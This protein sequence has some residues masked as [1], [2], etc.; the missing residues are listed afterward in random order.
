MID[1]HASLSEKFLKKGFWL[2]LFSFI[3]APMGYIIKIILSWE[4]NVEEIGILYG[5]ISLI[6]L[7]SSY[8]DLG[9]SESLK[10]FIPKY[11]S[12][13]RYDKVKTIVF[14]ALLVQIFTSLIIAWVFI[15]WWNFI[16][17]NYFKSSQAKEVLQV[18]G[19]FLIW[20]NIIQ[21]INQF[22]YAIQ[23]TFFSKMSDFIKMLFTLLS[24]LF[25]FFWDTSSLL[26]YSISWIIWLYAGLCCSL[27]LFY[28]FYYRKYLK[29][30]SILIQQDILWE[31]SKYAFVVFIW[32]SSGTILSQID[33]Q[34][35]IY[36]LWSTDAWYYT[37]YLSIIWIPFM[38]IWPIFILLFPVFSEMNAKK[39][40]SKIK[41]TKQLFVRSFITIWLMFNIF[42]FV[43]SEIIAFSLFGE[44][45]ILSWEILK[46]SI[47]FLL[48]NFL[49]QINFNIMAGI[50]KVKERLR[51]IL[52]A[53]CFNFV[54]NL[55]LI[56]NIW[57]YGA[58]L[59]TWFG[60]MLIWSLSEYYL[61]KQYFIKHDFVSLLKNITLLGG[62]WVFMFYYGFPL[63]HSLSR[64]Q[65]FL[66]LWWLFIL[67]GFFFIC[68]NYKEFRF[69]IGEI[70]KLRK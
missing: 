62:L 10:Y 32:A 69:F 25:I 55:I 68:I 49:L 42:F 9:M 27:I 22:F 67:W 7:I 59:A 60:W 47:L 33:M 17:E 13:N 48:F 15:F 45:F 35:I 58:A 6:V 1:Q 53:V 18:F 41:I 4:L 8:N 30:S 29:D 19:L 5:S 37:N 52:I 57:V 70:R 65:S 31:I 54:M 46:Y 21:T 2:Y 12:E 14:F 11:I 16:A 36:F 23:N 39:Q 38:L 44:K 3:I 66:L 56:N 43:F 64:I 63:F 20:F 51:I 50:W 61:G 26:N 40:Y 28:L 24:V 34:M